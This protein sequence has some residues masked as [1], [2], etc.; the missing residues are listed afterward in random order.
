MPY[1]DPEKR[2]QYAREYHYEYYP[3]HA[4]ERKKYRKT[5]TSQ[6]R[7]IW[8]DYWARQKDKVRQLKVN[9]GLIY[10]NKKKPYDF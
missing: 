5:R 9:L 2:K 3:E 1:K 7:Q 6:D 4:E 10:K 8:R